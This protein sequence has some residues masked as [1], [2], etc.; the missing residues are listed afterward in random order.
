MIDRKKVKYSEIHGNLDSRDEHIKN[1]A[2]SRSFEWEAAQDWKK[3]SRAQKTK[4]SK[5][6][7]LEN[8]RGLDN[9]NKFMKTLGDT[10]VYKATINDRPLPIAVFEKML[11]KI[12]P[13]L[14]VHRNMSPEAQI[15]GQGH[16]I[17]FSS[18]QGEKFVTGAGGANNL[19]IYPESK[20]QTVIVGKDKGKEQIVH[21][22]WIAA[23]DSTI[24]WCKDKKIGKYNVITL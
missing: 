6:Q 12:H 23:I 9:S 19:M 16:E 21:K 3:L 17:Y 22:G 13:N 2:Q 11:K 24:K 8:G 5:E 14:W 1:I 7:I 4:V 20:L 10:E 15:N 18:I